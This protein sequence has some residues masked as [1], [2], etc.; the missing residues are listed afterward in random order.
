[1]LKSKCHNRQFHET[2]Y[3]S[4][5]KN[6]NNLSIATYCIVSTN[7]SVTRL[8]WDVSD[9]IFFRVHEASKGVLCLCECLLFFSECQPELSSNIQKISL[10]H[11]TIKFTSLLTKCF[12]QFVLALHDPLGKYLHFTLKSPLGT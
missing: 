1:M 2:L 5:T 8:A 9:H 3:I 7:A 4:G 6:Q 12:H 10:L 11:C